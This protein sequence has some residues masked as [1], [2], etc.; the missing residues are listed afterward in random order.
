MFKKN[1]IQERLLGLVG[2]KSSLDPDFFA[3]DSENLESRSGYLFNDI[4]YANLEELRDTQSY[5]KITEAQFN[6]L[7]RKINREAITSV[8]NAVFSNSMTPSF[9]D[10]QKVYKYAS[11]KANIENQL[12][13]GFVGHK[14]CFQNKPNVTAE[15]SSVTLD[16]QGTGD[17][18]LLLYNTQSLAP[19]ESKVVS[20]TT[21]NQVETLNWYMNSQN[22]DY[23]LG[24][25]YDGSLQPY[26][27]DY[28]KANIES[29]ITYLWHEK[30]LIKEFTGGNIWDLETEDSTSGT[31][32]LNPDISVYNDYTDLIIQNENLFANAIYL[33][34]GI[35]FLNYIKSSVRSNKNQRL[36][37]QN[38]IM[39]NQTIEG[40]EGQSVVRITGL[41]PSLGQQIGMIQ[42]RVNELRKGYFTGR[43]K[44]TTL[45]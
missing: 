40:Q 35:S 32:G 13:N 12:V 26:K 20:I 36:T 5:A 31:T 30:R 8:S 11:N 37:E 9:I 14:F 23:Y 10:R 3:L 34:G 28:E 19:V 24:Y 15:I 2:Y 42:Q 43:I 18:T 6:E 33:Q 45:F 22:G 25:V 7:L 4:P 21:D 1:I 29:C 16:F 44:T 39:L 41:R 17:L 27:R 38:L